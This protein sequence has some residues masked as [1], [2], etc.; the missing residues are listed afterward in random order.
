MRS[1]EGIE[2]VVGAIPLG[3]VM[4]SGLALNEPQF[5]FK[6]ATIAPR[7]GHD[8]ASIVILILK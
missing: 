6:R 1:W 2:G 7:L 4:A 3:G 5:R 8:R